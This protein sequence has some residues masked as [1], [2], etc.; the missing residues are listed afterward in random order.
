MPMHP[1]PRRRL[2]SCLALATCALLAP[3]THLAHAAEAWPAKPIQL[4]I[5][6]PPGGSADL[7]S[8]A[9]FVQALVQVNSELPRFMTAR[10]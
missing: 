8:A 6:Y 10:Q 2:L 7:L 4:V 9:L 3:A 5:P 1:L